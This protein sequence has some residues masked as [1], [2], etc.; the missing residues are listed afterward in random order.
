MNTN[1]PLTFPPACMRVKTAAA[2][3][4]L[5]PR[6]I[7]SLARRGA[8]THVRVGRRCLLFKRSDLDTFLNRRTVIA[9]EDRRAS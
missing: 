6:H 8:L 4:G 7:R 2:Y 1:T 5:T 3:T 9:L